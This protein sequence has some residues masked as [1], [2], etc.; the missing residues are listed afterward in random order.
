MIVKNLLFFLILIAISTIALSQEI[1]TLKLDTVE[2]VD[3]K[4]PNKRKKLYIQF[5][6]EIENTEKQ[7]DSIR[8]NKTQFCKDYFDQFEEETTPIKLL[9]GYLNGQANYLKK[10]ELSLKSGKNYDLFKSSNFFLIFSLLENHVIEINNQVKS[11]LKLIN[12]ELTLEYIT[13]ELKIIIDQ[14]NNV[15]IYFKSELN[16]HSQKG[17]PELIISEFFFSTHISKT[18]F[19]MIQSLK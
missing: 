9:N 6:T 1:Y 16:C 7:L 5:L 3:S 12:E 2:I 8:F 19:E 13:H 18:Y 17:K 10:K 14:K 15:K 11:K 4:L